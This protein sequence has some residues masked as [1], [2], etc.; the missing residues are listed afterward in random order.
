M[1]KQH[2]PLKICLTCDR[3]FRWRKKWGRDWKN[4]KYCSEKCTRNKVHASH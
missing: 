1:K 4:V 3:P 2:L